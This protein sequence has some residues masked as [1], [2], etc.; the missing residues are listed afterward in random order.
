MAGWVRVVC[1]HVSMV[2]VLV[3]CDLLRRWGR[4]EGEGGDES[5]SGVEMSQWPF[6]TAEQ[7]LQGTCQGSRVRSFSLGGLRA[8]L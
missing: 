1:Q 3:R 5:G 8:P 2:Y 7:G 6:G 4:N